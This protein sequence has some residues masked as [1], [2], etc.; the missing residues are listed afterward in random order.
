MNIY[1]FIPLR[2]GSKSIPLKNIKEIAGKPLA[3]WVI[4]S[5]N[6]SDYIKKTYIS[7]DSDV[8]SDK[9]KNVSIFKRSEETATDTA[10]SE[11]ALIEFCKTLNSDD[12]VVFIQAT[13]PLL[14]TK[15]IDRGIEL[16]LNKKYDSV[17]SV[18]RQKRFIWSEDSVPNYD[19]KNRPRRQDWNGYLVENG[20]FYI[21]TVGNI[22]ASGCRL[23]DNIGMVECSE[24]S[25]YEID[26][27]SD[28]DIVEKILLEL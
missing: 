15:E 25:Y 24:N 8:I 5:S 9:L 27:I 17:L 7:T 20:A 4:D 11:S 1:A 28:W 13:S 2:S 16:I 14:K 21:N 12:I 19:I 18:V 26:E 6:A 22:L 3:Q 10:S 23:S